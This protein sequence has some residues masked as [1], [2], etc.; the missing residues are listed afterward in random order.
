MEAQAVPLT[1]AGRPGGS[2]IDEALR[3]V[4]GLPAVLASILETVPQAWLEGSVGGPEA[5]W[6][7]RAVVEHLLDVED[8]AFVGRIRRIV[9]EDEPF[10]RSID[11]P[12][13]LAEGGYAGRGLAEILS[14]LARRRVA[15]VARVRT[16]TPEQLDRTGTH[17]AAGTITARQLVHY[18]GTHDLVHLGQLVKAVRSNLEPHIGGMT[19]F[20]EE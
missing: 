15:D 3:I 17:D 20:L 7:P 13:R 19:R 11:P 18:W 9:E 14:E 4:E 2:G 6:S 12:A 5:S 8:I 1:D 10:I 16:L